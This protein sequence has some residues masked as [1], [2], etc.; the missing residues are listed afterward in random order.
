[1]ETKRT[2]G[3]WIMETYSVV[4]SNTPVDGGDIICE[5]PLIFEDSMRRW[6]ANARLIA[7]APELLAALAKS[8]CAYAPTTMLCCIDRR[9]A[10]AARMQCFSC[11][12]PRGRT[13]TCIPKPFGR[14]YTI[15]P[16]GNLNCLWAF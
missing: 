12:R 15:V 13:L 5:A 1:M 3:P 6:Q 10:M 2:P 16:T 8:A 7:A 11:N 14:C 9:E 4:A